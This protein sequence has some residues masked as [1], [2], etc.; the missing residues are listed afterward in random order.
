MWMSP[1]D[2]AETRVFSHFR[3]LQGTY[4]VIN[5]YNVLAGCVSIFPVGLGGQRTLAKFR[6]R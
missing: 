2:D 4:G 3:I 1:L 5:D 6:A